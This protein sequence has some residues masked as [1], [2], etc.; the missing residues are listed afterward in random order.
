MKQNLDKDG[1][2]LYFENNRVTSSKG[3][4]GQYTTLG[5]N[6]I[7][8]SRRNEIMLSGISTRGVASGYLTIPKEDIN[9]LIEIL[10]STK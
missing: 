5:V 7:V 6:V 9:E 10:N 1:G 8:I 3:R 2:D 4:N